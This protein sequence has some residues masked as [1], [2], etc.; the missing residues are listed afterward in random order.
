M[1]AQILNISVCPG[2]V[3][4][5]LTSSDPAFASSRKQ[6]PHCLRMD[7]YFFLENIHSWHVFMS[8][9]SFIGT[10]KWNKSVS[11]AIFEWKIP[12][13]VYLFVTFFHFEAC[14][15]EKNASYCLLKTD[16]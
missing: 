15:Q 1:Q 7:L 5:R 9:Q 14:R 4:T 8:I 13:H 2:F 3:S 6:P 10:N 12:F 11:Q 16:F